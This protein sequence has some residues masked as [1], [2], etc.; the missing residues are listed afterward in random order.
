MSQDNFRAI[1]AQAHQTRTK[2]AVTALLSAYADSGCATYPTD[3]DLFGAVFN[4]QN[5]PGFILHRYRYGNMDSHTVERV[6]DTNTT[7]GAPQMS[8]ASDILSETIDYLGRCK[9]AKMSKAR[10]TGTHI[11]LIDNR[12]GAY[13]QDGAPWQT[14][15]LNHGADCGHPTKSTA[16]AWMAEPEGWCDTCQSTA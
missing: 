15:C 3:S 11:I 5:P 14:L 10:S 1:Q 6:T 13:E 12:N 16:I 2:A 8:I 4:Y 9:L 7:H